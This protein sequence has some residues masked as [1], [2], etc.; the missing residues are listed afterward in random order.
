MGEGIGCHHHLQ[1]MAA[2]KSEGL[3]LTAAYSTDGGQGS[4]GKRVTVLVSGSNICTKKSRRRL[5]N[6]RKADIGEKRPRCEEKKH[7]Y[8]GKPIFSFLHESDVP[9][10]CTELTAEEVFFWDAVHSY[11]T[12]FRLDCC[13][14]S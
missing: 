13:A 10:K 9:L 6:I 7:T 12:T 3:P 4:S 1:P 8:L 14:F 11:H 5:K 2:V